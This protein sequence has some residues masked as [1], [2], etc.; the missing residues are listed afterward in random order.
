V[1]IDKPRHGKIKLTGMAGEF[2]RSPRRFVPAPA[3]CLRSAS[4]AESKERR[5]EALKALK[6]I[7]FGTTCADR[8]LPGVR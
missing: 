5:I 8:L 6:I 2:Y 7:V 1:A 3:P 4:V